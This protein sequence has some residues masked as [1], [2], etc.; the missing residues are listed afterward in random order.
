M[1]SPIGNI[2]YGT[3]SW[4]D[5]TLIDSGFYPD[6]IRSAA[7]RLGYYASRFPLVEVD[8]TYYAP[9]SEANSRR[10]VERTPEGFVFNIKAYAL[11]THHPAD[12]E[13][14]PRDLKEQLPA[15]ERERGRIY[16]RSLPP[17]A[18]EWLWRGHESALEPLMKAGKLGAVLFQFPHWFHKNRQSCDYLRAIAERAPWPVAVEFRGGGWMADEHR[19][20]STLKLL[21]ELGLTYVIVDEPQGFKSSTPPVVERTSSL[22]MVRFHGQNTKTWEAKGLSAAERFRYRY[23][24][25]ELKDWIPSVRH[26]A[27]EADR[28]HV[29]FNNCY[30]DYAARNALQLADL[31]GTSR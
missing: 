28:V 8:S 21:E 10:W 29:L 20:G 13:R 15:E 18:R 17:E 7:D 4:T 27:E 14:M 6:H 12:V 9:P 19:A 3:C 26:L 11:L 1:T 31:L 24:E 16:L 22:A 5:Q 2:Y 25:D 30:G 23:S